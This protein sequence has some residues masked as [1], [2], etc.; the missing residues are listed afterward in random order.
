METLVEWNEIL[1]TSEEQ[2]VGLKVILIVT[3]SFCSSASTSSS[4][5]RQMANSIIKVLGLNCC[6][7]HISRN[8]CAAKPS[9]TANFIP[10]HEKLVCV[11]KR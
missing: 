6:K 7:V 4:S 9:S 11:V 3:E 5:V 1:S 10:V 8:V 2:C